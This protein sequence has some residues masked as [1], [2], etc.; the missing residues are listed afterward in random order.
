M[1][2]SPKRYV[3]DTSVIVKWF[4]TEKNSDKAEK[5]LDDLI[6]EKIEVVI[7]I[8]LLYELANVLW[9]RRV[10]YPHLKV[11]ASCFI[12]LT[13]VSISTGSTPRP[14]GETHN[15]KRFLY[16]SLGNWFYATALDLLQPHTNCQRI[17]YIIHN[18][19]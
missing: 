18:T 11:R 17:I 5:L 7:P 8:S 6:D 12:D 13:I 4:M 1:G 16:R 19:V 2:K 14:A 9:V 10:N 3:L 15:I